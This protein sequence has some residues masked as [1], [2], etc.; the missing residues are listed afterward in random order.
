MKILVTGSSGFIGTQVTRGLIEDDHSLFL[1]SRNQKS[2]F[3][4]G[5]LIP[6]MRD[7]AY[8]LSKAFDSFD[9]DFVIHCATSFQTQPPLSGLAD[10]IDANLTFGAELAKLAVSGNIPFINFSS[11]WQWIEEGRKRENIY[12]Q[13]KTAFDE[14]LSDFIVSGDPRI[15]S[16]VLS[17]TYHPSDQRK[18]LV[19]VLIR[20]V[21][22]G[23]ATALSNPGN[24]VNIDSTLDVV[25]LIKWLLRQSQWP[26]FIRPTPHTDITLGNLVQEVEKLAR[27]KATV[28]WDGSLEKNKYSPEYLEIPSLL[29]KKPELDVILRGVSSV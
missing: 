21:S 11:S 29:K 28:Q 18:K 17:E 3:L 23:H 16:V 1:T 26:R 12:R 8:S 7:R 25:S 9:F 19:P 5:Q 4:G 14:M 22:D 2:M 20:D 13:T 6:L 10:V 27:R 24:V 15:T